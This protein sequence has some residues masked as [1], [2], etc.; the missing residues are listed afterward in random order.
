V[1]L[2][3]SLGTLVGAKRRRPYFDLKGVSVDV[4]EAAIKLSAYVDSSDRVPMPE[5]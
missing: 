5:R 1:E 3:K 2:E 4:V